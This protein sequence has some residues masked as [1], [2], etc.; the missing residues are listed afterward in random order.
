MGD[1]A[2]GPLDWA[3]PCVASRGR[4]RRFIGVLEAVRRGVLSRLVTTNLRIC[5]PAARPLSMAGRTMQ[6]RRLVRSFAGRATKR[7]PWRVLCEDGPGSKAK[8]I[9]GGLGIGRRRC[10]RN[11]FRGPD[12]RKTLAGCARDRKSTRLN[13]SHLVISYA[14]FCLKKQKH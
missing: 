8:L 11:R 13:S 10:R 4:R 14:V 6:E 9:H 12:R 2:G 3:L 5:A 7:D 1:G